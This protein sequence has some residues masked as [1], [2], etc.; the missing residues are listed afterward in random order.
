MRVPDSPFNVFYN[1][2]VKHLVNGEMNE[3][4]VIKYEVDEAYA[5][6]YFTSKRE[7]APF[8]GQMSVFN[9]DAFEGIDQIYGRGDFEPEPCY[10]SESGDGDGGSSGN[11]G[12]SGG[13]GG[14]EHDPGAT[15]TYHPV[16]FAPD[17]SPSVE[18]GEGEWGNYG[19][20]GSLKRINTGKNDDCPEEELLIP[21]NEE[22]ETPPSC[23]SFNYEKTSDNWQECNVKGIYFEV[24]V[25]RTAPPYLQYKYTV[26]IDEAVNFGAPLFDRFGNE[27]DSGSLAS[28]SA[29]ALHQAIR[30]TVH[31]FD[32]SAVNNPSDIDIFFK[33][34][35]RDEF[36]LHIIGGR[37]TPNTTSELQASQYKA[38]TDPNFDGCHNN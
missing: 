18:V 37:A 20:D 30:A 1:V 22:G 21:I 2:I 31:E 25:T 35:L 27:L 8:K 32:A 19:S 13:G 24:W 12:S 38:T 34:K 14:T 6:T 33:E 26:H 5:Y 15:F 17:L 36:P 11:G 23:K 16:A 10:S 3:P 9:L 29:L 4:F 7:E 28:A